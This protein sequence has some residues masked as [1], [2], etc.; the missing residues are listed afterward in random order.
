MGGVEGGHKG[1]GLSFKVALIGGML[2]DASH[3]SSIPK[4]FDGGSTIIVISIESMAEKSTVD[5]DV[6]ELV[7]YVKDTPLME[8]HSEVLLPAEI[9]INKRLDNSANGIYIPEKTISE[10][11]DLL[12]KFELDESV[13][14]EC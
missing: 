3:K 13:I 11:T 6:N 4:L 12:K 1:Y 5:A 9:E 2:A 8:N 10:L 14:S 7:D